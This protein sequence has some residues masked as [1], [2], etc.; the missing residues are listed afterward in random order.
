[1]VARW[2]SVLRTRGDQPDKEKKAEDEDKRS[3]H[4]RGSTA[5]VIWQPWATL[6]FPPQR[7]AI[8]LMMGGA[9]VVPAEAN[10]LRAGL[11][12]SRAAGELAMD[13]ASRMARAK[14]MGFR[15]DMPLYHGTGETFNEFK[16]KPHPEVSGSWGIAGAGSG[17]CERIRGGLTG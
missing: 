1:M 5:F 4:A 11:T 3:P 9:G 16:R 15:T 2:A 17:D 6:A 7:A 8:N 12:G 13:Q 14:E 10:T